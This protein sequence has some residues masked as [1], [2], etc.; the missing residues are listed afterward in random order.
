[1]P[2]R[3]RRIPS[4]HECEP[5]LAAVEDALAESW[6]DPMGLARVADAFARLL[7]GTVGLV[8]A[9]EPDG[10]FG[11]VGH[12]ITGH[13]GASWDCLPRPRSDE[14]LAR[15]LGYPIEGRYPHEGRFVNTRTTYQDDGT[16][17]VY[18]DDM[19]GRNGVRHHLRAVFYLG[20][21]M[22]AWYGVLGDRSDREFTADETA[23][24][25][26]VVP[27]LRD[28]VR[29][30]HVT[31]FGRAEPGTLQ[32]ILDAIDEPAWIL[33]PRGFVVHANAV[34]RALGRDE[35]AAAAHAA[36]SSD[37]D[38]RFS[39]ARVSIDGEP[40][41]LVVGRFAPSRP[42]LP[43]SLAQVADRVARGLSDK[44]IA[45]DLGLPLSTV[46]TYVQRIYARLGVH[47]R[48]ELA[49]VWSRATR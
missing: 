1:M 41:A 18:Q 12:S 21:R 3:G 27:A 37:G 16:L 49:R 39:V 30:G 7:P 46:R 43:P 8:Y 17:E 19:L 11:P 28:A 47:N 42:A 4:T 34:A 38:P 5:R 14:D 15:T 10:S 31:R 35:R 44:E 6:L 32:G 29:T 20:G 25:S 40:L 13:L 36:S 24:L 2:L 23:L 22:R 26:R 33:G 45:A 9:R 48:V